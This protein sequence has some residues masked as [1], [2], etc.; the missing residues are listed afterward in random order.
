MILGGMIVYEVTGSTK[1][2]LVASI[3]LF[4]KKLGFRVR[5]IIQK[6]RYLFFKKIRVCQ[7]FG[8]CYL[9]IDTI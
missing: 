8:E 5:D 1:A 3:F 9:L 2:L 4:G 6:I 7:Q